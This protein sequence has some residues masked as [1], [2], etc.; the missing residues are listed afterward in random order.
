MVISQS[1][2]KSPLANKN[3]CTGVIPCAVLFSLLRS[4]LRAALR[5]LGKSKS[6]QPARATLRSLLGAGQPFRIA[7]KRPPTLRR[8]F[9]T[10]QITR[11]AHY[12][13]GRG[14]LSAVFLANES[15]SFIGA[16]GDLLFARPVAAISSKSSSNKPSVRFWPKAGI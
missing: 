8:V 6:Y 3:F 2:D 4:W 10:A 13:C 12:M 9:V 16:I 15:Y 1:D 14:S 5:R 11:G 7:S